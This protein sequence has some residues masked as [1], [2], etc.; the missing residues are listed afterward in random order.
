MRR[1]SLQCVAGVSNGLCPF[2][3][4]LSVFFLFLFCGNCLFLVPGM[5]KYL[6]SNG[7]PKDQA[8]RLSNHSRVSM[9]SELDCATRSSHF[10]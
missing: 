7:G 2:V 10:V 3:T 1:W 5:G 4:V 6:D 9:T 8:L